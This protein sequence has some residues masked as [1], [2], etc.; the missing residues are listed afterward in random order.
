MVAKCRGIVII[1]GRAK[2][3]WVFFVKLPAFPRR[4]EIRRIG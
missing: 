4:G 2:R 1:A 3:A